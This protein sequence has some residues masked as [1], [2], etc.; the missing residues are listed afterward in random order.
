MKLNNKNEAKIVESKFQSIRIKLFATLCAVIAI[1]MAFLILMN[2][3]VLETYYIHS[4]QTVLLTAY[5]AINTFFN[6]KT[7]SNDIDFDIELERLSSSNDIDILITTDTSVYASSKDFLYS[8]VD[9]EHNKKDEID[10]NILHK[11][12]NVEIRRTVDKETDLSFILLSGTLDNGYK[13]YIRA[14]IAPIQASA[15]IANRFLM[16]IGFIAIFIS[17]I[18]VSVISRKFTSPIEELNKITK[19]ISKLDFSSKYRIKDTGDEIDDLRKKYK[20]HV[21]NTRKNNK[22]AQKFKHRTRKRH[23]RKIENR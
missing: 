11:G 17:I 6:R 16:L 1:I 18:L 21:R 9:I 19:K 13:L 20:Y 5:E 3:V 14:G 8:V 15:K 12:E 10:K 2:S 23:R 7:N 22:P 4:K